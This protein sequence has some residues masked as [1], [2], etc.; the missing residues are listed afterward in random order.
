M[1]RACLQAV[2]IFYD[3]PITMNFVAAIFV[4]AKNV[5]SLFVALHK[6]SDIPIIAFAKRPPSATRTIVND[7]TICYPRSCM[8]LATH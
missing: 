4:L 2:H 6:F 8:L 5:S 3:I 1:S 7:M